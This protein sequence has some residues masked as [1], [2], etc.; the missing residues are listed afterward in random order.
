[1]H[2]QIQSD[3]LSLCGFQSAFI[4]GAAEEKVGENSPSSRSE[5]KKMTQEHGM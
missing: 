2:G 1:M 3:F 5:L 4:L